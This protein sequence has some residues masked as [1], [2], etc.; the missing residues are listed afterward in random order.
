MF[1]LE[2]LNLTQ[3]LK[4]FAAGTLGLRTKVSRP[5][6]TFLCGIYRKTM[7]N[8]DTTM[9]DRSFRRE[10]SIVAL[11][12]MLGIFLC[13]STYGP[14]SAVYGPVTALRAI[15]VATDVFQSFQ[16]GLAKTV[17][18]EPKQVFERTFPRQKSAQVIPDTPLDLI[19]RC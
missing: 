4:L 14:Y 6:M 3:N 9:P 8:G 5:D 16:L 17:R 12:C 10:L 11:L 2:A 13:P 1:A 18:S 19:L 15:R 7:Y